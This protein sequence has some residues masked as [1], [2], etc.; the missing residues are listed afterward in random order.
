MQRKRSNK[1]RKNT[2]Q[3]SPCYICRQEKQ[4][5][6]LGVRPRGRRRS[7]RTTFTDT[8]THGQGKHAKPREKFEQL[9][10]RPNGTTVEGRLRIRKVGDRGAVVG[11]CC[12]SARACSTTPRTDCLHCRT[13]ISRAIWLFRNSTREEYWSST[14]TAI[15]KSLTWIILR[16]DNCFHLR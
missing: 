12:E 7:W 2:V 15:G 9:D 13:R 6:A 3:A 4:T 8:Q 16:L 1:R 5:G 14:F 11:L 10:K